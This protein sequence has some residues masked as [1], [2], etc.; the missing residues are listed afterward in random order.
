MNSAPFPPFTSSLGRLRPE[1]MYFFHFSYLFSLTLLFTHLTLPCLFRTDA[2]IVRPRLDK[3]YLD[4]ID[5]VR[6]FP[7]RSFH[8]LV[9][10]GRLVAWGLGPIPSIEN[11]GH[12][13]TTRRSKCRP[14]LFPFFIFY[15]LFTYYFLNCF[16]RHGNSHH[17][18][19]Q[20]KGCY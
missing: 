4:R 5:Q 13:E 15:F 18:G 14:F 16:L 12:E 9:T 6:S 7:D 8:G 3:F 17:E 2:A 11:L 19:K 10:F 20:G 1:G